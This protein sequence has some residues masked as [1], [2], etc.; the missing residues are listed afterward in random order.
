MLHETQIDAP[1]N[2]RAC[3]QECARSSERLARYLHGGAALEE[4]EVYRH[5]R[6]D[7]PA[8]AETFREALALTT[9]LSQQRRETQLKKEREQ[10]R[11]RRRADAIEGSNT[12]AGGLSRR[13]RNAH[14]RLMLMPAFAVFIMLGVYPA[15]RSWGPPRV[16]LTVTEGA[17]IVSGESVAAGEEPRTLQRG[18]WCVLDAGGAGELVLKDTRLGL[19]PG[20][21]V[22]IEDSFDL[23]VRLHGG[24]LAI[25]GPCVVTTTEGVVEV[26]G[27]S[28][29]IALVDGGLRVHSDTGAWGASNSH[30]QLLLGADETVLLGRP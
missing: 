25:A 16:A 19:E 4:H 17:V 21:R 30:S 24:R 28:G 3:E 29:W 10:R 27:G 23:R 6:R 14:L 5:H 12:R 15:T 22:L 8:C 26:P 7:C 20:T 13:R 9:E 18:D 2:A 11:A 1:G